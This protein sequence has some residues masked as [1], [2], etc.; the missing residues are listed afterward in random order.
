MTIDTATLKLRVD[1]IAQL[2]A[3]EELKHNICAEQYATFASIATEIHK[4]QQELLE[5]L[6]EHTQISP[7]RFQLEEDE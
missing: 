7:E 4:I 5:A 3:L 2:D 6:I 1:I